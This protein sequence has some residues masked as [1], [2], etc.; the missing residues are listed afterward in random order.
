M[1]TIHILTRTHYMYTHN[2]QTYNH[3]FVF[4]SVSVPSRGLPTKLAH[5]TP[6]A[7]SHGMDKSIET[8]NI[9]I[10]S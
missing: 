3:I 5:P 8:T 4:I 2:A 9:Y 6:L 1:H 10:Y 7:G